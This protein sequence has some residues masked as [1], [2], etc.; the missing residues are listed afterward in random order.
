MPSTVFVKL[1]LKDQSEIVVL[2]APPS[3]EPELRASRGVNVLRRLPAKGPVGFVLAFVT[4]QAEV[5]PL[6]K[7]VAK[8]T[9]GDAVVWF[10]Y[11]KTGSKRYT[12]DLTRDKGWESL[13]S[14]GF[15]AVRMVAIDEDW[16]AKRYRRV[17]FIKTMTRDVAGAMTTAGKAK[18]RKG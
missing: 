1:N 2:N 15:E 11:P 6:A 18:A 12:T 5:P 3:F 17:E 4:R 8:V 14:A 9:L 13:G 16:S 10:A 7:A